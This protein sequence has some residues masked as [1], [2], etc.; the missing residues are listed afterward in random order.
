MNNENPLLVIPFPKKAFRF[1]LMFSMLLLLLFF[2]EKHDNIKFFLIVTPLLILANRIGDMWLLASFSLFE[3]RIEIKYPTRIW[4]RT[5]KY[6]F[7]DISKI[8]VQTSNSGGAFPQ[9]KI[10][11]KN[12]RKI[13][14][15]FFYDSKNDFQNFINMIRALNTTV[16]IKSKGKAV[17]I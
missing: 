14:K 1:G 5:S 9:F 15:E 4:R 13:S 6:F 8:E 11:L 16:E 12:D 2:I 7:D 17:F 3:N 10:Y